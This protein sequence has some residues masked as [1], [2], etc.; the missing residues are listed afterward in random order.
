[1]VHVLTLTQLDITVGLSTRGDSFLTDAPHLIL[2]LSINDKVVDKAKLLP[3]E[4]STGIW[5]A[6]QSLIL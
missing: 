3:H 6:E 5:Q 4:S 2:E 1:M